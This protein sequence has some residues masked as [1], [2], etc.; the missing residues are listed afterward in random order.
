MEHEYAAR[1]LLLDLAGSGSGHLSGG[2]R[3]AAPRLSVPRSRPRLRKVIPNRARSSSDDSIT[4]RGANRNLHRS[5]YQ[6]RRPE[7]GNRRSQ[8]GLVQA[9]SPA[10]AGNFDGERLRLAG[11]S[12]T[13]SNVMGIESIAKATA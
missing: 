6:E 3:E 5:Y 13:T 2:A 8:P 9:R 10:E 11:G 4:R 12:G 7:W 1:R